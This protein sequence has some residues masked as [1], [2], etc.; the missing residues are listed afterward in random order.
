MKIRNLRPQPLILIDLTLLF[1]LFAWRLTLRPRPKLCPSAPPWTLPTSTALTSTALLG[2]F[3]CPRFPFALVHA[4][5]RLEGRLF[6]FDDAPPWTKDND[7]ILSGY[8][9]ALPAPR[10]AKAPN[11]TTAV[12]YQ[13]TRAASALSADCSSC[14]PGGSLWYCFKSCFKLHNESMNIWTHFAGLAFFLGI[15][16]YFFSGVQPCSIPLC[17]FQCAGLLST[18]SMTHGVVVAGLFPSH[19]SDALSSISKGARQAP[20]PPAPR[21]TAR[22]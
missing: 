4:C 11:I 22:T 13:I 10:P 8:R 5:A 1:R 17:T 2:I 19:A 15:T 18:T 21:I 3:I 12:N 6:N 7:K 14:R 9:Q 20:P 16:V